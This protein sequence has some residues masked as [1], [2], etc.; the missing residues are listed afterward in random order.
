MNVE[1]GFDEIEQ[2]DGSE[3]ANACFDVATLCSLA[4]SK[5]RAQM[6]DRAT[7]PL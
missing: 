4:S 6:R 2:A 1:V 7:F 5:L 3:G